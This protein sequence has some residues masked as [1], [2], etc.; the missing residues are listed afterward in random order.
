MTNTST[1]SQPLRIA[2]VTRKPQS[3]S[4][5][6]R[7]LG[8][9]PLLA[10][11]NIQVTPF[12]LPKGFIGQHR[13][14]TTLKQFDAV[15]WHRHQLTFPHLSRLKRHARVLVFDFDDPVIFSSKNGGENSMTRQI[16]FSRLLKQCD[17]ALPA[18]EYLKQLALPYCSQTT[19]MPMAIDLPD[20]PTADRENADK[21]Q[22]LWLGSRSTQ[23]YLDLIRPALEQIGS[24][25]LP[26]QLRLVA[27][28]PMVF[29]NLEVDFRKWSPQQQDKA[30]RE[31][32]I[33]LC[34]MPDT[35][36]TRGKCPFK[37]IQYMAHGLPWI[38]SAVGENVTSA[39]DPLKQPTGL[40]ADRIEQWCDAITQLVSDA[41]LRHNM[42]QA[43]IGHVKSHHDR[44]QLALAL[45]NF[46]HQ[47]CDRQTT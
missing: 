43:G 2:A 28:E 22:L 41:S 47:I 11:Q 7:V 5:A 1:P 30:L 39:G 12:T 40:C 35:K 34:P 23:V 6:Q 14:L 46:W 25:G 13:F 4:Y 16:R 8:Y 38:G 27:H 9:L 36:W 20:N 18:S 45:G 42:G 33:G 31:C 19:I 24:L 29:G 26:I 10:E 3:A 44:K 32:H 17:A 37:V 21:V 15:W